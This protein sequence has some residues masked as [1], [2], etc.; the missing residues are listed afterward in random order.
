MN[1]S[2]LALLLLTLPLSAVAQTA[3]PAAWVDRSPHKEGV[4]TA[5]GVKLHYLDWGG[6]GEAMLFLTGMGVTPHIFDNL[7]PQFTSR[8]RVLGFT[9]R[10]L[11]KSDKPEAGYD[12]GTLTE[13]VGGFLDALQIKRATLIGWS[14]AGTEMTR[15]ATLYPARV[16]RLIFLDAAYDY[17]GWPEIWA[18]D[19]VASAPT[20]ED[21]ASFEASRRWFIKV[22][23]FWSDAV[24]ADGRAI[25]LQ[26]DG[27][28][29]LEAMSEPITKQLLD[30]MTSARPDFTKVKAPVLA[31]YAI[32]QTHPGI[33]PG[34]A[35]ETHR[36][37][38]L[39]WTEVFLPK[40][41]EQI[42]RLRKE[43]PN[44]RI[45]ELPGAQHLCFIR[46]QDEERIK[47][48][49]LGFLSEKQPPTNLKKP[50]NK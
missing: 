37:A 18:Q 12:T 19:P 13:D 3:V 29:K 10:G 40:Q 49:M 36:K 1:R 21:L 4:V 32:S 6:K 43:I 39:Y 45:I 2:I 8:F 11:G 22:F 9:R 33:L 15:F 35:A 14:L 38:Q 28:V 50:R 48:E 17:A 31:F 26:P 34:T 7:A 46:Q 23:G 16:N 44:A 30:G 27:T 24:E 41:R 5:N 42:A 20:K 47:R 25:N